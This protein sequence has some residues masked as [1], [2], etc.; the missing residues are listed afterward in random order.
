MEGSGI[1]W[2]DG[3]RRKQVEIVISVVRQTMSM[4]EVLIRPA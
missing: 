4:D 3:P 1:G 2:M